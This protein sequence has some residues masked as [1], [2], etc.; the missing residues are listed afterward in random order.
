MLARKNAK[1]TFEDLKRLRVVLKRAIHFIT[2]SGKFIGT[3]SDASIR[4]V[5]SAAEWGNNFR[6][7][8]IFDNSK[9]AGLSAL[10]GEL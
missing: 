7:I 9:D 5:L 10:N 8:S 1:L 4:G 6:Q 3:K 2:C